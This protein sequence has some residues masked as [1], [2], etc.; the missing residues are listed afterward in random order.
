MA[1][2]DHD[3]SLEYTS[4]RNHSPIPE[5]QA[6]SYVSNLKPAWVTMRLLVVKSSILPRR[7]RIAVVDGYP[8]VQFGRDVALVGSDTARIRLKEMEVSKFHATAFWDAKRREWA[9]VDMGSKHGTYLKSSESGSNAGDTTGP[10]D[11]LSA[12][13]MSSVPR[14]IRHL[15]LLTIGS[16]T[17]QFHIHED[18][19]PCVECSPQG[20]DEIP[21]FPK[22]TD[23][24]RD[25]SPGLKRPFGMEDNAARPKDPKKALTMLRQALLTRHDDGRPSMDS[26]I[27]YA[28]RSAARRV[29][30]SSSHHDAPG[31]PLHRSDSSSGSTSPGPVSSA[32]VEGTTPIPATNIGHQLL[33]KQGWQ[34]G[35]TLGVAE[36]IG[37]NSNGLVEPLDID[38]YR[39]RA[40]LG[41]TR[42][43][44]APLTTNWREVA[45]QR[46]WDDARSYTGSEW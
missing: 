21:L 43:P 42:D 4:S 6:T 20:G 3:Q 16:T 27:R 37:D 23:R 8:E 31:V 32:S 30:Q 35:T 5:G 33:L 40:G 19:V 34:P 36:G 46:R 44:S 2:M 10:G 38:V 17:F 15:D 1:D 24:T 13:K 22:A 7:H 18:H 14:R 45:R 39:D 11:R 25:E 28:D 29:R 26:K 12:M 9:I 41:S